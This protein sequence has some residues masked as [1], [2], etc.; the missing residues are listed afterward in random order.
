MIGSGWREPASLPQNGNNSMRICKNARFVIFIVTHE[1]NIKK[2]D[3]Y[4]L[5]RYNLQKFDPYVILE[6][7]VNSQLF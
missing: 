1:F 4:A 6:F 3:V 5:S 2:W 7:K